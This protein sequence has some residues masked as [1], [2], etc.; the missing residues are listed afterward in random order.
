VDLGAR[1][2]FDI[3]HRR[4]AGSVGHRRGL[5]FRHCNQIRAAAQGE[6]HTVN[7]WS[8]IA[9][10]FVGLELAPIVSGEIR[11]PRRDLPRAAVISGIISAAFYIGVTAAL[12][13]LLKPEQISPM[14]GLAQAGAAA[15][16]KLGAPAI[17]ILLA[18]ADR[19]RVGRP[20][21]HLD[22]RKYALALRHWA[23]SLPAGRV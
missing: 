17:S 5:T 20:T 16:L 6:S 22:R 7:F 18:S 9:F 10:A 12:L 11:N 3:H 15:A 23:G 8:Q 21:R 14:T 4:G 13:V 19:N 1:R 2:K